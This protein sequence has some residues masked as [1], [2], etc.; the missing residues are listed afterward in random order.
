MVLSIAHHPF[1]ESPPFNPI[2]VWAKQEVL[3][4]RYRVPLYAPLYIYQLSPCCTGKYW[5]RSC[6][7][8]FQNKQL[9]LISVPTHPDALPKDISGY[10]VMSPTLSF[11]MFTLSQIPSLVSMSPVYGC[12]VDPVVR[13]TCYSGLV[14]YPISANPTLHFA[15]SALLGRNSN[16]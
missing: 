5:S 10:V 15:A 6:L 7:L 16:Q 12:R 14:A 8:I 9:G 4:S 11:V 3:V 2:S 13:F 1:P